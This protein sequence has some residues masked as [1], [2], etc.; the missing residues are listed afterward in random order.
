[1][2]SVQSMELFG[3]DWDDADGEV[4]GAGC[5]IVLCDD[6]TSIDARAT[7][8][9][10][11]VEIDQSSAEFSDG[12]RPVDWRAIEAALSQPELEEQAEDWA[13]QQ[14]DEDYNPDR[15]CRHPARNYG[16]PIPIDG[17]L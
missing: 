5:V 2:A 15:L 10:G 11:E 8:R 14:D 16:V 1:M 7:V 9:H 17:E 6:G 3:I 4:V 12:P 13:E